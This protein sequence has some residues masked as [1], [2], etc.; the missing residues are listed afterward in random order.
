MDWSTLLSP[1]R[2][3]GP[4]PMPYDE[5]RYPVSEF[6]KDYS[7]IIV[8]AAFRRLQDKTQVFPLDKSDFVRTR[9]TH[10]IEV[11][12]LAKTIGS[13][14]LRNIAA[15]QCDSG[16]LLTPEQENS[17]LEIL[18]CAGLLHDL[19]NP[20]FGHFGETVIGD[21]FSRRLQDP[22]FLYREKPVG[23]WLTDSMR[24]DLCHFEGNAQTLRLLTRLHDADGQQGMNLTSPL[25]ATL[26]KYPVDSLHFDPDSPDIRVHKPGFFTSERE[27]VAGLRRELDLPDSCARH[28]LTFILEAADDIAYATADLEDAHKKGLFSI[29]QFLRFCRDRLDTRQKDMTEKQVEKTTDLLDY[30]SLQQRLA[31]SEQIAF[32]NWTEYAR[33]WLAY[34]AAYGFT[35]QENYRT[36]MTGQYQKDLFAGTFHQVSMEILG[37]DAPREFLF[38]DPAIVRLELSAQTILQSL[39]DRFVPAVLYLDASSGPFRPSPADLRLIRLISPNYLRSYR[40]R[41]T[42]REGEDLY[43]RLLLAVDYLS[44]M[45]D[46]YAR[47]LYQTLQGVS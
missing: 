36:I 35:S 29:S 34:S 38:S 18:T 37:R 20:P 25:L 10:S 40:Q 15:Y 7:K 14:A 27:L 2:S 5:T 11:S 3:G 12:S 32:R 33:R 13:M 31:S 42:G 26:I 4:E 23:A 44:G 16:F 39:L 28:P 8:S 1:V 47:D 43:L 22:A 45:T 24:Q 19:G 9:L 6:E 46:S 41:R 30:L 17:V 21:W